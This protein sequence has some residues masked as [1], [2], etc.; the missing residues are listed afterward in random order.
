LIVDGKGFLAQWGSQASELRWTTLDLFGVNPIA[1]AARYDCLGLVPMIRG[2]EVVALDDRSATIRSRSGNRL[3]YLRRPMSN[4]VPFWISQ[5][6]SATAE[7]CL[8]P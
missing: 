4:A 7:A 1:P 2:D 8:E 6:P 3:T 5:Y